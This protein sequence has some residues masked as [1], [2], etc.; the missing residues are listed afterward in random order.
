MKKVGIKYDNKVYKIEFPDYF[1]EYAFGIR[2]LNVFTIFG[3]EQKE[4]KE[5]KNKG[6][7]LLK[8]VNK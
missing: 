1:N 7:E 6:M 3:R 4:L 8:E 5:I 2:L